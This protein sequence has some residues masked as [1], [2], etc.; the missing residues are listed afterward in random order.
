MRLELLSCGMRLTYTQW[1]RL[2]L[3]SPQVIIYMIFVYMMCCPL[4]SA[5]H[6]MATIS[7]PMKKTWYPSSLYVYI[8]NR[9]DDSDIIT[10]DAK[11]AIDFYDRSLTSRRYALA[12]LV[13][14]SI[15]SCCCIIAGAVIFI[16]DPGG[17]VNAMFIASNGLS[18]QQEILVVTLNLIVTL[19]TESTGFIHN[20]SLRSALASE[21][22]L[23]FN[24]NLRLL[25]TARGWS[26]PN[27]SLLNG[28]MVVVLIIVSYS[29]AS[30]ITLSC[31]GKFLT[32]LATP[33]GLTLILRGYLSCFWVS[34]FF[35]R[36]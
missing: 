3:S 30:L 26:N 5:S 25:T 24:S 2:C 9:Q 19:C 16:T 6:C 35:S 14:S 22:R 8:P 31:F 4:F 27:G 21:S 12:G 13:C 29:S 36:W 23:R 17:V 20:I 10:S 18:L 15:V 32:P 34:R 7:N 1:I 28:I 11:S 33:S